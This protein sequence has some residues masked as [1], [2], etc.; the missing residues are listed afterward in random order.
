MNAR[1]SKELARL[2]LFVV[3]KGATLAIRTEYDRLADLLGA[4]PIEYGDHGEPVCL[5]LEAVEQNPRKA[6]PG[7]VEFRLGRRA[8]RADLEGVLLLLRDPFNC[9]SIATGRAR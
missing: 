9:F 7:R 6:K 1:P 4:E 8:T 2:A 5:Y 3:E